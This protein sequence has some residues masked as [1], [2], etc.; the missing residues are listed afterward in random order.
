MTDATVFVRLYEEL[1]E[2][3]PTGAEKTT[4]TRAI[5]GNTQ[6]GTLLA[7][8][9][10]PAEKIELVLVNGAS[11]GFNHRLRAGD[12]VS[13]YP[14]FESMD[15]SPVLRARDRPLRNPRFVLDAHLGK[16][17]AYMRMLGFDCLYKNDFKDH[18]LMALSRNDERILLSKDQSLVY[19]SGLTRVYEVRATDPRLQLKEILER[20]DL[21]RLIHP[22]ARCMLCNAPLVTAHKGELAGRVPPRVL[23]VHD[24]FRTCPACHKVYWAGSHY[25]RMR[26]FIHD[27]L[28]DD[29]RD[30][31]FLT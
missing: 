16:L 1:N 9:G 30:R 25:Q 7:A 11:V 29:A 31:T 6:A 17:A 14:V 10:I 26:Q 18:L 5:A 3:A 23:A 24:E 2:Y 4:F 8:L 15:V 22:F 12:R 27:V 20:F 19:K 21:Y 28:E 13:V